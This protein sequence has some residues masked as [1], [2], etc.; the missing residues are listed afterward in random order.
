MFNEVVSLR[1]EN[2]KNHSNN[3]NKNKTEK[4]KQNYTHAL[5]VIPLESIHETNGKKKIER[6]EKK[7]AITDDVMM[8]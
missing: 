7:T 5:V 6:G 3:S 1:K 4:A 2:K 8:F